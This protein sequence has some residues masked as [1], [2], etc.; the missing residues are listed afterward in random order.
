MMKREGPWR[1]VV[2]G[3]MSRSQQLP[4]ITPSQYNTKLWRM[5]DGESIVIYEARKKT[6]IF[7]QDYVIYARES[8]LDE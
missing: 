4:D 3:S 7:H 8:V 6:G 5:T 1:Q 2:G